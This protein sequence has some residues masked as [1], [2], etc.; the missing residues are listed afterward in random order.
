MTGLEYVGPVAFIVSGAL[1]P[2]FRAY[3]RRRNRLDVPNELSAHREPTPRSGGKAIALGALAGV[4]MAGGVLDGQVFLWGAATAALIVLALADEQADLARSLRLLVQLGVAATTV[5]VGAR[6]DPRVTAIAAPALVRWGIAVIAVLWITW[7]I[8]AYNFMD[9]VNGMAA[10]GAIVA[11]SALGFLFMRQGDTAGQA[12]ALALA[13]GAAGF[14][15]WNLPSGSIFMG[16]VGSTTL[17]FL[18]S[19]L[20]LRAAADGMLVPAVLPLLP[21]LLDTTATLLL[22]AMKG[23]RFFSTRHRS[24]FYQRLEALGWPH[25]R[26][27]GLWAALA[28]GGSVVAILYDSLS[29]MGRIATV[30]ALVTVHGFVAVAIVMSGRRIAAE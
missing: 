12:I 10:A 6:M 13:G 22:R 7:M 21:F 18:F 20:V 9:G 15:P 17:G 1:T 5:A 28:L 14:L 26:V 16:D 4:A 27:A 8:N 11:G 30:A 3:S 19:A 23:E 24:H 2:V 25:W 29:M